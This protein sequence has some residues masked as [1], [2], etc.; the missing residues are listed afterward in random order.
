V[1]QMPL[2]LEILDSQGELIRTIQRD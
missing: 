2:Y 1:G